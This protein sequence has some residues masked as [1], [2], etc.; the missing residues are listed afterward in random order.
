VFERKSDAKAQELNRQASHL[1]GQGQIQAYLEHSEPIPRSPREFKYQGAD[2]AMTMQVLEAVV[3]GGAREFIETE[4]LGAM[5]IANFAWETDVSGLPKA[6]A[7]KSTITTFP[8]CRFLRRRPA[9]R[10]TVGRCGRRIP[11]MCIPMNH[12]LKSCS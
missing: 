4:L 10:P 5:G 3:P 1:K 2:P 11:P 8:K 9:A 6:A 12:R 7:G